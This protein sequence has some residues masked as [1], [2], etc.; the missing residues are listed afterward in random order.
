MTSHIFMALGMWDDVVRANENAMRISNQRRAEQGRDPSSCGHVNTWLN[1]GWL[2]QGRTERSQALVRAC[3]LQAE[4]MPGRPDDIDPDNTPLGS[5]VFIW[6]RYIVDAEDWSGA[7]IGWDPGLTNAATTAAAGYQFT[8]GFAA[9]RRGDVA[10]GKEW[11]R[12]FRSTVVALGDWADQVQNT[13]PT[14]VEYLTGLDVMDMQ[15]EG[16]LRLASGDGE[17]GIATLRRATEIEDGMAYAFGPPPVYKP[18][19]ELLGEELD[20][21]ELPVDAEREFRASLE[22]TPNRMAALTGLSKA[23][24]QQGKAEEADSIAGLAAR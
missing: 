1:Y 18:S 5:A 13:S 22:F 11:Q 24:R 23:L 10:V 3:G 15:L 12:R 21:L 9:V 17:G 6:S 14:M 7:D 19:H 8:N 4:A 16:L 20:R 2:Q